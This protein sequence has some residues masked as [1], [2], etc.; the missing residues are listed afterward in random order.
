[1][2]LI[3]NLVCGWRRAFCILSFAAAVLVTS[4]AKAGT[5]SC[6]PGLFPQNL[7]ILGFADVT[8]D[9][10][11]VLREAY[12]CG[13][14]KG[15][16]PSKAYLLRGD[17][18]VAAQ[19]ADGFRC[20]AFDGPRAQ[21]TGWVRADALAPV[22]VPVSGPWSGTWIRRTGEATLKITIRGGKP[23]IAA[24][25]TARAGDP[26]NIRTGGAEGPLTIAGDRA[27]VTDTQ[28][29]EICVLELRKLGSL[30]LAN[31]GASDDGNSPCGGMGVTM[32][33]IYAQRAR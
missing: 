22:T 19:V 6:E 17:R 13:R 24:E 4:A 28:T 23:R 8:V 32:N 27:K 9:R 2:A 25:A 21:T 12:T 14:P 31:D 20:I 3:S 18:V 30:I 10:L 1:M 16:C 26:D 7:A 29:G 33:G 11:V 5:P 15:L